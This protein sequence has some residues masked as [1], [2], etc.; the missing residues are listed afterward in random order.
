MPSNLLKVLGSIFALVI[1]IT[2]GVI[3]IQSAREQFTPSE[4][5]SRA[6]E[7]KVIEG[8]EL[9]AEQLNAMSPVMVDEETRMEKATVGP[10]A[11]MTY[12]YTFPNFS[13]KD[14]DVNMMSAS[15]FPIIRDGV[16]A[17]AE[18]K[19]SLQY[20]GKYAYSYSGYD[21]VH[22]VKFVIDRNDCSFE[23]EA[24]AENQESEK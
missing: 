18:M 23:A 13:S 4:Q 17:S 21:G 5:N 19:P 9:A 2:A 6:L 8:F 12:H 10:G 22:I 16:C 7:T 3:V 11:L 24:E 20:G 1:L 14:I 15:V